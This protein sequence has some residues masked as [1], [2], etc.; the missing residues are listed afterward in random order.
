MQEDATSPCVYDL[1][2]VHRNLK[3]ASSTIS[4]VGDDQSMNIPRLMQRVSSTVSVA[5]TG[6]LEQLSSA[7]MEVKNVNNKLWNWVEGNE[8]KSTEQTPASTPFQSP[9]P[10]N[11]GV[12][13]E[14]N[15]RHRG[16]DEVS[17]SSQQDCVPIRNVFVN[18]DED[19]IH[20]Q[21][22]EI[23]SIVN[24]GYSEDYYMSGRRVKNMVR[25][26]DQRNGPSSKSKL[27]LSKKRSFSS[28]PWR[29]QK[30]RN[31][32]RSPVDEER[33]DI[34]EHEIAEDHRESGDILVHR[35]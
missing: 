5:S 32:P 12:E 4:C 6:A 14:K 29:Q 28:L 7:F 23:G 10:V 25:Y 21:E 22:D 34:D 20:F 17:E 19:S 31:R 26:W 8:A 1:E 13:E 30:D 35:F 16:N 9:N 11:R 24:D 27:V 18:H 33:A 15:N 2:N 3:A